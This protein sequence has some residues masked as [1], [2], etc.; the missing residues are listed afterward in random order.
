MIQMSHAAY[1]PQ[2]TVSRPNNTN[3][4]LYDI[5]MFLKVPYRVFWQ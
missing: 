4:W 2:K 5:A 1:Q 3:T